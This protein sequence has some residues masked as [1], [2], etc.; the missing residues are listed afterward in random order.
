MGCPLIAGMAE[1]IDSLS[2]IAY[3]KEDHRELESF[4]ADN[5]QEQGFSTGLRVR[6]LYTI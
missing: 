5:G 6:Q 4:P 1:N 3:L 2:V